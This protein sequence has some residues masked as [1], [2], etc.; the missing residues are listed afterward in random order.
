VANSPFLLDAVYNG[1]TADVY[2]HRTLKVLQAEN[3]NPIM[4]MEVFCKTDKPKTVLC[5]VNEAVELLVDLNYR[6]HN[7]L[8]DFQV[9]ALKDGAIVRPKEVVMRIHGHYQ[10]FCI[11]ETAYLGMLASG[12]GWATA[13]RECVD[14][15]CLLPVTSFGARHVHPNCVAQ[16]DYAAIVGGCKAGSSVLG[17]KYCGKAPS[18]T[19]PHALVINM[20]GQGQDEMFA[21]GAAAIYY[22][23]WMPED[24]TRTVLVD[25]FRDEVEESI[26]VARRLKGALQAVRFDTPSERGGVKPGL[27][28][29]ARAKLDLAG[30][31]N[32]KILVSGGFDPT[33]I[34]QFIDE[35]AP[36]DGFGVGSYISGAKPIDFTADIHTLNGKT[37][38][39]CEDCSFK[40]ETVF[41][42]FDI[43]IDH[44]Y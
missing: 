18:G 16:M 35:G 1:D 23:K 25:T 2:F 22:D 17:G 41:K 32:V 14:A 9:W 11:F 37:I 26:S 15:A 27:V 8:E 31:P 5:G 3:I 39:V 12:T 24:V 42:S 33:R 4:D 6:H 44:Q 38:R 34:K 43:K 28:K 10:D 13:A 21:T 19:M 20:L 30:F 40:L 36:V 29:E 7:E